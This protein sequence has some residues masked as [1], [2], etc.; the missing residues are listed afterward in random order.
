MVSSTAS[1]VDPVAPTRFAYHQHGVLLWGEYSG[2]TVDTGRFVGRV[3][4]A[5]IS[6][7]F[8]HVRADDG[9]CVTGSAV[10]AVERRDDGR[11][12]LVEDFA[13]DGERHRS[14]CVEVVDA[15]TP[16]VRPSTDRRPS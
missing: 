3:D 10:S 15:R 9:A 1:R 11:V 12:H 16:S 14:V 7:S 8:A 5:C 4:G 6:I 2:D 13:K